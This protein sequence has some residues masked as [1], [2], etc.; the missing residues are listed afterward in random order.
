MMKKTEII[1]LAVLAALI[2]VASTAYVLTS[3]NGGDSDD[4]DMI[5]VTMAWQKDIVESIGGDL[6]DV[7][8]MLHSSTDPH[9]DSST[10]DN[11]YNLNKSKFY[12]MIGSG[13]EWEE[14]FMTGDVLKDL[15]SS[16]E[17]VRLA[18]HMDY[19]PLPM[20]G[21]DAGVN[22]PH[23]W[24]SPDNLRLMASIIKEELSEAYPEHAESFSKNL[25]DYEKR[26]DDVDSKAKALATGLDSDKTYTVTCWH[27][28]W[29]YLL[30]QYMKEKGA[31]FEMYALE[32]DGSTSPSD[33]ANLVGEKGCDTVYVSVNDQGYQSRKEIEKHGIEVRVVNPTPDDI[34]E[35]IDSFIGYLSDDLKSSSD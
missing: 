28:A 22:D 15:P 17:V 21:M 19:E 2:A 3:D 23:I 18:E 10:V 1:V 9:G 14:N 34:L 31:S 12:F 7:E 29:Q 25:L 8:E 6:F 24:T 26:I 33:I 30:E 27:P 35:T 13:V 5:T 16:V 11:V 20:Y 32:G 4:R